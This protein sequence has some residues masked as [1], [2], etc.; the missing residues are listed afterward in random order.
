MHACI[1]VIEFLVPRNRLQHPV[2]GCPHADLLPPARPDAAD[3]GCASCK[4]KLSRS[5]LP[6]LGWDVVLFLLLAIQEFSISQTSLRR[7]V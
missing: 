1:H 6:Y 5:R 2:H 4:S 7:P 3:N